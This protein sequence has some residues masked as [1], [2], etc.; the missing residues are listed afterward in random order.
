MFPVVS[1]GVVLVRVRLLSE[2]D[3]RLLQRSWEQHGLLVVDVVV[4]SAV[5]HQVLLVGELLGAGG[6]V[7]GLVPGK[8]VI[9]GGQTQVPVQWTV[10]IICIIINY[11]SLHRVATQDFELRS[12]KFG[13]YIWVKKYKVWEVYFEGREVYFW[14]Q[15]K[16]NYMHGNVMCVKFITWKE[17]SCHKIFMPKISSKWSFQGC[18]ENLQNYAKIRPQ[19]PKYRQK[20]EMRSIKVVL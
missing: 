18:W 10:I 16:H 13:K 15:K 17:Q 19:W 1:D 14:T 4:S 7:T 9:R 11:L 12:I 6:H 2:Q 8:I 3:V 5:H 20:W